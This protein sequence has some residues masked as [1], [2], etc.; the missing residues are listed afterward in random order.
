M[1]R[2]MIRLAVQVLATVV[3]VASLIATALAQAPTS[4]A[5]LLPPALNKAFKQA[6]PG[7]TI[8]GTTPQREGNRTLFRV[9]SVDKGRRRVVL[10]EAN[11]TVV[12]VAAQV[13][14]NDLPAAVAAAMHSHP[15]AIYV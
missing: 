15:R 2:N 11:G 8:S 6:Y 5:S 9:D 7:A 14:E 4:G 12:E 1:R 3:F 13:E 10:Y